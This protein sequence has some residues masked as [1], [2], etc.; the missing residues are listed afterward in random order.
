M[1]PFTQLG[2]SRGALKVPL[3]HVQLSLGSH[4]ALGGQV[5]WL[6]EVAAISVKVELGQGMVLLT[7]LPGQYEL[8]AQG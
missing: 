2:P 3:L 5:H 6:R 7:L 4:D 1:S 8:T